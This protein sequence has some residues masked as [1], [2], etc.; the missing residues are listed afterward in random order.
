M[1]NR[2]LVIEDNAANLELMI[3]LLRAY[4]YETLQAVDGR[5]GLTLAQSEK[6][7]V[8]ICD[9]QLPVMNGFEV[10]QA[11][12]ADAST[13]AIP[14]V[15]VTA[16]AM[17]GDRERIL[18]AGFDGYI[19]KP[20]D[21]ESFVSQVERFLKGKRDAEPIRSAGESSNQQRQQA[22]ALGLRIL[23]VDNT[24]ANLELVKSLLLP[25]GYDVVATASVAEAFAAA[26]A[27]RPDL[28]ISDV[29]MPGEN[30]FD[31]LARVKADAG[32]RDVPFMLASATSWDD[33]S[34]RRAASMGADLLLMR[35][36]DPERLLAKVQDLLANVKATRGD[37]PRR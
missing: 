4:R 14:V 35:P 2:V 32:L 17:V 8:I 15:A 19:G 5:A 30:G 6:P 26:R 34:G 28:I 29:H 20:I 21:P 9:V 37:D 16:S 33:D 31:F 11:L 10:V 23:V 7:A 13:R 27:I 25:L 24:P 36:V 1:E 18:Q 12:K 3:Y 22:A